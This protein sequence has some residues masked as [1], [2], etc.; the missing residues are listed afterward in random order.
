M[1][2]DYRYEDRLIIE[3]RVAVAKWRAAEAKVARLIQ[4]NILLRA[5]LDTVLPIVKEVVK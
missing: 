4:E 2:N 1:T 5:A 3:H